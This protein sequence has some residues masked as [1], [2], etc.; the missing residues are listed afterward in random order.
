MSGTNMSTSMEQARF[1]MVE[2]QARPWNVVDEAVLRTLR[3]VPREDFVQPE[4]R[5]LAFS[6]VR[7]PVGHDQVMMKPVEESRMLQAL[8]LQPGERVLEIVTGSGFRSEERRV[9]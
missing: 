9:G 3:S 7:I 6:D 2:Q 1:I 5:R 8:A 4:Y